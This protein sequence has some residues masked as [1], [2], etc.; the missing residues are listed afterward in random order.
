MVKGS[1]WKLALMA[2][3]LG[4]L[5]ACGSS[6]SDSRETDPTEDVSGELD[7]EP[8]E[9]TAQ[10]A[11]VEPENDTPDVERPPSPR[12]LDCNIF[13]PLLQECGYL[14]LAAGF[15][16]P[17]QCP[18][19]CGM[20]RSGQIPFGNID[21]TDAAICFSNVRTC[22][23]VPDCEVPF[24]GRLPEIDQECVAQ[25]RRWNDLTEDCA[26]P[27]V[28][29]EWRVGREVAA[30][31]ATP[32][33][34]SFSVRPDAYAG[35]LD[36]VRAVFGAAAVWPSPAEHV[37][38]VRGVD[39]AWTRWLAS[40][41]EV[42][43]ELPVLVSLD[44][45][46]MVVTGHIVLEWDDQDADRAKVL[47]EE[48]FVLLPAMPH[49]EHLTLA[50]YEGDLSS[51][52]TALAALDA[53]KEVGWAEPDLLRFYS[54]R[55]TG[56]DPLF[57]DQWHL[58]AQGQDGVRPTASVRAVEAWRLETGSPDILLAINDD[59]VD[60]EHEDLRE[61]MAEPLLLQGTL[62]SRLSANCCQHGTAVAGVAAAR[63][64]ND[65]GV[66]GVCPSCGIIP[67]FA[68][69]IGA[70]ASDT[71]VA[72]SFRAATDAGAAAINNSWG[73]S[74]GSP[75][76]MGGSAFG[77][78]GS[79]A[80]MP[81]VVEQALQYA[82]TSGRGGKGMVIIFA[83]GNDNSESDYF[84]R[85][86]LTITVGSTTDQ[87]EK[88]WYSSWG[89]GL[90]VMA[91][92]NGGRNGILT[93]DATG[94]FGYTQTNY[95]RDF[96]GTSS[97]APFVTGVV[98]LMLSANPALTAAEVRQIL[99]ETSDKID[100]VRA[101]YGADGHS[102]TYGHG[103]VNVY[104]A[105]HAA[106]AAA[107]TCIPA[108]EEACNGV[109]DTCDGVVD[110]GCERLPT[111]APCAFNEECES[112]ICGLTPND[113][114]ERCLAACTSDSDCDGGT[115]RSGA[116][117]PE[118][119]RCDACAATETC[120][121]RDDT[122]SGRADF[123]AD[124]QN[125]C[126]VSRGRCFY[127]AECAQGTRCLGQE[128]RRL[129][130]SDQDCE[131]E[132]AAACVQAKDPFGNPMEGVSICAPGLA[133]TCI[134]QSCVGPPFGNADPSFARRFNQCLNEV[135]FGPGTDDEKCGGYYECAEWL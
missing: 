133:A 29:A 50:R 41:P 22:S 122:C 7:V 3:T 67:M 13:C 68:Q 92:S 110:T 6:A 36:E 12:D 54:S 69:I 124:N 135:E 105:V 84:G 42:L 107:D 74:T 14:E 44:G 25:C 64:F 56:G 2:M 8:G 18:L 131:N 48:G 55:V 66:R 30:A 129:C 51:F 98:G 89:G 31:V 113:P 62:A 72:Q 32:H 27:I 81:G 45:V 88:A 94:R 90:T 4:L 37:I 76:H 123:N 101:E 5:A 53:R 114:A 15:F 95:T 128:C 79:V 34:S 26:P 19:F 38:S 96:G 102:R 120:N 130:N 63:G 28:N 24:I 108:E 58:L 132:Q 99:E 73:L 97:A 77:G 116:C 65:I 103:R 57:N 16:S 85:S 80:V 119:G 82:L 106:L 9:D 35:L 11:D 49:L 47:A 109:D 86:P 40:R 20:L 111:C 83:A 127:D 17:S 93:T 115:C 134:N 100:W 43:R 33:V 104:R 91:P 112:G 61:F 87:A 75:I 52:F 125:A 126:S 39:Q 70:G 59:G 71:T 23:Q 10:D 121:G 1:V 21:V 118:N 117:I 78:G 60:Y 46:E